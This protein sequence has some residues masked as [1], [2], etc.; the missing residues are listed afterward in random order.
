MKVCKNEL[1]FVPTG[2]IDVVIKSLLFIGRCIK[3]QRF[4]GFL[5]TKKKKR[6][7]K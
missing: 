5:D 4:Y 7:T 2:L 6:L 3:P 1:K